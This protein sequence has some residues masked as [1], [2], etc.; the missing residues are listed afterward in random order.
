M[1]T[2]CSAVQR[3]SLDIR[4]TALYR[5]LTPATGGR[6]PLNR[7]ARANDDNL[8]LAISA[9]LFTVFALALGDACIKRFSTDFRLWQ[10]FVLRSLLALP[11]THDDYQIP[12]Q[13]CFRDTAVCRLDCIAQSD[14]HNNVGRLLYGPAPYGPLSCS[15]GLLYIADIH[16]AV[17]VTLRR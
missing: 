1:I 4:D 8:P 12:L 9:I 17:C 6:I 3:V 13:R 7:P 15:G 11:H 2:A 5:M 14:A 10:I 16:N